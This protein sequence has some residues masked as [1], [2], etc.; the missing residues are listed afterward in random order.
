MPNADPR[1]T[2]DD[3]LAFFRQKKPHFRDLRSVSY[4]GPHAR[5]RYLS[6]YYQEIVCHLLKDHTS[7]ISQ[8]SSRRA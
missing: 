8:I 2:Y 3:V 1:I 5:V 4:D 6:K 7:E